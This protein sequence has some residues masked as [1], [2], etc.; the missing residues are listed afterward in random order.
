M[1]LSKIISETNYFVLIIE[2]IAEKLNKN[3]CDTY[4]YIKKYKGMEFLYEFYDVNHTL[5]V[6]DVTDD[7]L[8]VCGRNGGILE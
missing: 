3:M 6:N 1:E 7:V 4:K 5:S 8:A 2:H